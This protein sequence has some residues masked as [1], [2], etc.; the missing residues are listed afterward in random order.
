[1]LL[2]NRIRPFLQA[3]K[4]AGFSDLFSSW[5]THD[6]INLLLN[7]ADQQELKSLAGGSSAGLV[8]SELELSSISKLLFALDELQLPATPRFIDL[9]S[10]NGRMVKQCPSLTDTPPK[11]PPDA[12]LTL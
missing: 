1:M 2:L 4:A 12:F 5:N 11:A 10:G 3:L 7:C 8:Y 6:A 9:G